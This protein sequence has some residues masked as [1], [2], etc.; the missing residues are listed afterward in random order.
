M[1]TITLEVPES[2]VQ[3]LNAERDRLPEALEWALKALPPR[4]SSPA[5]VAATPVMVF[6]EMIDFL[7]THPS[8]EQI[9]AYKI[10]P[11][12]QAR[13][14]E[15]LGKNREE[16]MTEAES[17]ELDWYEYVHEIMTRLKAQSRT[18]VN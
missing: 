2:M 15:L 10:S 3:R 14:E 9:L 11:E 4:R 18:A 12:A 7:A 6:I 16:D 17:A 13:L 5:P 8:T 1:T